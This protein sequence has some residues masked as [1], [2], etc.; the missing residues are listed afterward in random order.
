[1][2]KIFLFLFLSFFSFSFVQAEEGQVIDM[3]AHFSK[4][5]VG[6]IIKSM[7]EYGVNKAIFMP[8]P[9]VEDYGDKFEQF[10]L[11]AATKFPDR[12]IAFYGGS[13][14]N[15]LINKKDPDSV[16]KKNKS[17]FRKKIRNILKNYNY[18][19]IGEIAPLH[20]SLED[21]QPP[22]EFRVD[23]PYMLIL[24]DIA[25]EYNIPLDVHME[26]TTDTLAQ[27]KTLLAHNKKAKIIW[28]H[29]G[30]SNTGLATPKKIKSLMGKYH[31]LYSSI[32]FRNPDSEIQEVNTLK[33]NGKLKNSWKNLFEKYPNKFIIGTDLKFGHGAS[34]YKKIISIK[35]T[36]SPLS[37]STYNKI[38]FE[39]AN[40]LL[41]L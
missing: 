24:A 37:A 31:N 26:A 30:W 8:T 2:K 11:D 16:T 20:Y 28:D 17:N 5:S 12:I 23:H 34:N 7:D 27:F 41:G 36:L 14:I 13:E 6:K 1:M 10:N 21:G 35:N 3:H 15:Y 9:K 33:S 4:F 32:K 29:A 19:G 22:I 39:N 25:E 38:M 40:K 18:Q